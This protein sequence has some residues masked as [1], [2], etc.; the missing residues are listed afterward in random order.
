MRETDAAG[1]V[2]RREG[3]INVGAVAHVERLEA[4]REAAESKRVRDE[5]AKNSEI[6]RDLGF[7]SD[8]KRCGRDRDKI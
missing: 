3:E 2:R 8:P 6:E 1:S 7:D 4:G 5:Y